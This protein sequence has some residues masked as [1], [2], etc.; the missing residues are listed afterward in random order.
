MNTPL[1]SEDE[2]LAAI[3]AR[4]TNEHPHMLLGRGDDCAVLTCPETMALTTDLFIEDVHFRRAYFSPADAG[5]KALAVNVSDMAGMGGEPVGFSLGLAGPP[6]TPASYWEG[7]LDGMAGLAREL[8]IPL[9]GGD[10]NASDK[11]V[12]A[13]TLWGRQGKG[14]RFLERGR[15]LPG[16]VLFV[17]GDIGLAR[18]GLG[19]LEKN[20]PGAA[21][22][23][24]EAV[25]AHLRPASRV[26]DGLALANIRPVRGLMDVS[27][28][29][30][31]DL[32]RFLGP[33][34]GADIALDPD[35]L[36]PEVLRYA[37]LAGEDPA[38]L[39]VLGGED[40][41]LLGACPRQIFLEVF[42]HVPGVWAVGEVSRT[43]GVR[44]G[45]KPFQR[46]G[47]DHFG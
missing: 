27:D 40:Y 1:R 30:A 25:A 43:P 15:A 17:V 44:L 13:V 45:G 9:V 36:H 11:I 28:G 7:V 3:S 37:E 38:E 23:W 31:R 41:A 5:H 16:D 35:T 47:F 46:T 26:A 32:P 14:G 42:T 8:D 39:A 18:V 21:G 10:L 2:F 19:V 24:P 12:M 4:F 29:L 34:L 6:D 33:K 22:E 20:G